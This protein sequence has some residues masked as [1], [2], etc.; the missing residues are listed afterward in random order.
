MKKVKSLKEL[1][2]EL[3]K[4][5]EELR[6]RSEKQ[7]ETEKFFMENKNSE[8]AKTRLCELT[9][10]KSKAE[11]KVFEL[12]FAAKRIYELQ[13][14]RSKVSGTAFLALT[15]SESETLLK[16]LNTAIERWLAK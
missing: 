8:E 1:E 7:K 3:E 16:I 13:E 9:L 11:E 10:E 14:V 12:E 5:N 2:K 6:D 15:E 4:A